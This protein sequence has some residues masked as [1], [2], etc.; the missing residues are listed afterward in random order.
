MTSPTEHQRVP[1]DEAW[2]IATGKEPPVLSDQE[3]AEI[4][5]KIEHSW[6]DARRIYGDDSLGRPAA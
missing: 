1:L 5:A 3:V 6:A 2:R 4:D